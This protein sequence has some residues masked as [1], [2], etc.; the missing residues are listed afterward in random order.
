MKMKNIF[1][2]LV[3]VLM[4]TKTAAQDIHLSQFFETPLLRNPA[5]AGIFTGN[6]RTQIVYRNQWNSIGYPYT[7]KTFS[8]EYK[9]SLPQSNDY[10]TVGFQ[11][12][13][14]VAG[15]TRLTTI[16]LMPAINFHK[17]LSTEKNLFLSAG[18]AVGIVQRRFDDKTLTFDNQ[19]NNGRFDPSSP[20]GE[21]LTY[22]K[23]TFAD[24]ATGLSINDALPN[25][26]NFYL[27]AALYHFNKPAKNYQQQGFYLDPKIQGNAG[28][29]TPLNDQIELLLEGNYSRQGSYSE[30]IAGGGVMYYL[31]DMS[32]ATTNVKSLAFGGALF[33]RVNDAIIPVLKLN[34]NNIEV[35]LSYDVNIST[36]AP[37]SKSRGGYELSLSY[38]G[39]T[40][41]MNSSVNMMRCPRF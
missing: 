11:G 4:A 41:S 36:L 8:A 22:F 14:D 24:F 20:S 2:L 38:R 16:D 18:F 12:F 10:M 29:K 28:L 5:L 32:E 6:I 1:G 3:V 34:Y 13:H 40:R 30:T 23:A 21:N 17:S 35:G 27:G 37:A 19:Y 15:I 39:F 9:F 26:G 33:L 7:T 31:T 25:G